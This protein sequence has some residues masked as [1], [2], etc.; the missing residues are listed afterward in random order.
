MKGI[1]F[2]EFLDLVEEK[3][4]LEVVDKIISQST[5]DS[6]GIYTAIGT[7]SFSEMLQLLQHLSKH[8]GI[9]IDDLLLL[10]AEHFF[11]V[12]ENSYPGLLATYKEPIEM[13]ASIENHI[14]VEVQKIYPDAEL[15]TFIIKERTENSLIMIYKSSR[16]MHHF[17]LGLMNKTFEHFNTSATIVL[18]KI[19]QDG[20]EVKFII[21]KN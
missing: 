11:S 17:G 21:H 14:H 15:P 10:Y 6:Q 1:V 12:I 2:T 13:L 4:G 18:E 3:F 19:K 5:L 16:A 8:S 7:Y 20:T 9:S